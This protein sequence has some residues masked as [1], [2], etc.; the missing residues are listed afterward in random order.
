MG[1]YKIMRDHTSEILRINIYGGTL[2][3][4]VELKGKEYEIV[5]KKEEST[6][7]A[8]YIRFIETEEK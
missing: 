6:R 1:N 4:V 5:N 3:D 8:Y 2:E 7:V